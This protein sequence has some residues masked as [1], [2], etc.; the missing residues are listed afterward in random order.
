MSAL[1]EVGKGSFYFIKD[2]TLLDEF[3][4]DALGGLVSAIGENLEIQVKC[5]P[6]NPF[7]NISIERTFGDMWTQI[8]KNRY[9]TITLPQI[10][11]G[12]KKDYVFEIILP[13]FEG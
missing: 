3:F 10:A 12:A 5:A 1:S 4:A 2:V 7:D 13:K 8:D 9:Y 11:A 6:K